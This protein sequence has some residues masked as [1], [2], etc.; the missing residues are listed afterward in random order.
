MSTQDKTEE[1][2]QKE[3]WERIASHINFV[4]EKLD[5]DSVLDSFQSLFAVNLV[6]G[7]RLLVDALSRKAVENSHSIA[8]IAALV[9]LI[10]SRIRSV[11]SLLVEDTVLRFL[12]AFRANNARTCYASARL[13]SQLF[14]YGAAHEI[15]VLQ[16]LHLLTEH[17]NPHSVRLTMEILR[18]CGRDLLAV[19]K[20]AHD[21]VY[22]GLRTYFQDSKTSYELRR[23]FEALF[24]LRKREYSG[25]LP[26]IQLPSYEPQRHVYMIDFEESQSVPERDPQKFV[27]DSNYDAKEEAFE[28]IRSEIHFSEQPKEK[29]SEVVK[30][31]DKTQ[32]DNLEF[33]KKIYLTLKGSLSGDEAAHK[34]LKI[35]VADRNK[36]ILVD[37]LIMACS[38]ETTY[39]KF[40]GVTAER[41][42]SS[43]KSWKLAFAQSFKENYNDMDTFQA[44][45][46]RNMGK[47]WG[48]ILASD[49][50]GM[51]VLGAVHMN[52]IETT[53]AGRVF[54][55]FMLQ[56]LVLD[57][58][59]AELKC[60]LEEP[61]VQPF[62]KELFPV[63]D[64]EKT[65]FSIN[66]FTAIGL[67]PLTE[68]M[69]QTLESEKLTIQDQ[70]SK[71]YNE[72]F[73]EADE[74]D[75]G[76]E[77]QTARTWEKFNRR[78][79]ARILEVKDN[80][81]R[82]DSRLRSRTPPRRRRSRTPT[83]RRSRSPPMSR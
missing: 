16:V 68:V 56:E 76:N 70:N 2:L 40:Y 5:G 48:H 57:L 24:E 61:W 30:I 21:L 25:V 46:V 11:G 64:V 32:S 4:V 15:V 74:S 82:G 35:R 14:N 55:K 66:F 53:P 83:R 22:E 75:G 37:T 19:A 7:D 3:N 63:D 51:D 50:V 27:F 38:Q 52:A 58:G 80:S 34:L 10:S 45:Q 18:Q 65:R 12:T 20:S 69:R 79:R 26:K 8:K 33:K 60:R 41:L 39:S 71:P 9:G 1:V 73:D 44:T 6:Y 13:L 36:K 29:F 49:Y 31:E 54:L 43:H 67:G 17:I 28:S 62:L 81:E 77:D 23:E 59:I 72:E 47:L 78:R 42:C